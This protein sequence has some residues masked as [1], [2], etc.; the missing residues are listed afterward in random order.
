[1]LSRFPPEIFRKF[2]T[3]VVFQQ[4]CFSTF[5]PEKNQPSLDKSGK[6]SKK[7]GNKSIQ[8]SQV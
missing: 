8:A 6:R 7:E 2:L 1:M 4:I 5:A 3:F